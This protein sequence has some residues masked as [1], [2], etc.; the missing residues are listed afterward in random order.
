MGRG[1]ECAIDGQAPGWQ[2]WA[3]SFC[4]RLNDEAIAYRPLF[5]TKAERLKGAEGAKLWFWPIRVPGA[6]DMMI[7]RLL[8]L[9]GMFG[10]A[11]KFARVFPT[12]IESRG[13]P[14]G[15]EQ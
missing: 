15:R 5:G 10:Y 7:N 6:G 8:K 11:L 4:Q 2:P 13:I 1:G 9:V 3:R 12:L 14:I